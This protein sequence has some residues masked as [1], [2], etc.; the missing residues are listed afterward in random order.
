LNKDSPS[1]IMNDGTQFPLLLVDRLYYLPFS[2]SMNVDVASTA[3]NQGI[4]MTGM[5][6]LVIATRRMY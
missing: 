5:L 3:R 1:L 6:F 2:D 4:M